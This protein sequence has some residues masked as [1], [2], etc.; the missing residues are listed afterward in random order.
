MPHRNSIASF[1]SI[2][3]CLL[4]RDNYAFIVY[5]RAEDA[6]RAIEGKR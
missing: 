1:Y 3:N 5:E 2:L 6:T 4:F